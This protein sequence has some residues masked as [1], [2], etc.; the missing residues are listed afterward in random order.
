VTFPTISNNYCI[1]TSAIT[2]KINVLPV[3]DILPPLFVNL[4]DEVRLLCPTNLEIANWDN[5]LD[6]IVPEGKSFY[7][8]AKNNT[9][10]NL[11]TTTF[12]DNITPSADLLLHW[13]IYST[14]HLG[15]PITDL[16]GTILDN[17]TGQISNHP[18]NFELIQQ[19]IENPS[20]QVTYWLEDVA[21]NLT[22][23]SLRH[24]LYITII[25]R[26]EIIRNF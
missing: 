13:G 1:E 24:R 8:F 7:Y 26:P 14:D 2:R 6:N 11:S 25:S 21:G 16:S 18:E 17:R 5:I 10:F 20:L 15:T 4:A 23:D 12:S 19:T 22:P 9:F 3:V